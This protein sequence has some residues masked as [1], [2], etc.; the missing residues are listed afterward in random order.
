[1]YMAVVLPPEP[2]SA[3]RPGWMERSSVSFIVSVVGKRVKR[4][5]G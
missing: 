3:V 2:M 4:W 1:V 5:K